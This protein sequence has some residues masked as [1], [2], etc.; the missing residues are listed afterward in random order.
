VAKSYQFVGSETHGGQRKLWLSLASAMLTVSLAACGGS[1]SGG[2][3]GSSPPVTITPTPSPSPPPAPQPTPNPSPTPSPT[4]TSWA[5]GAA[6]LY[7]VQPNPAACQAGTLK[8]S[9]RQEMLGWVNAA[10]ALHGLPPVVHS[11]V[12][13]QATA[14]ASLMMAVNRTLSHTPPT[15]WTCYTNSGGAVAGSSNLIGGWGNGLPWSSEDALL[16]GWLTERNSA[17]IGHRRW[18]L[19]PFLGQI[20]YGRVAYQNANGDRADSA[21]MKMFDFATSVPAPAPSSVPAFVAYPYG[22]YPARY[23][24]TASILSFTVIANPAGRFASGNA[25]V[26]FDNATVTV[27]AAGANLP[28]TDVAFDNVGYGVPNSLQ[29]RVAGLQAGTSYTVRIS[30]VTGAPQSVY[31]YSFRIVS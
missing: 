5:A 8:A 18:L 23:F 30:G 17:T 24:G 10:R 3:G 7:D 9:V 21:T 31:E 6:A 12:A 2:G 19:D 27:S 22:N 15:S 4:P 11:D 25:N 13:N 14:E 26:R 16:A 1:D 28:V 29:W 20:T